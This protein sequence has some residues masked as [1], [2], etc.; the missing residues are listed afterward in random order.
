MVP[1]HRRNGGDE[2]G[3]SDSVDIVGDVAV[4]FDDVPIPPISLVLLLLSS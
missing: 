3:V 4:V 1:D 2:G